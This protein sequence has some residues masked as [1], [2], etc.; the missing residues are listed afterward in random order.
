MATIVPSILE[1]SSY[2]FELKLEEILKIAKLERIQIDF[3]DGKFT[4]HKIMLVSEINVLNPAYTWEAHLMV[5]NPESYLLDCKI[6][7]FNNCLVHFE[8][9]EDKAGLEKIALMIREYKMVPALAVNHETAIDAIQPFIQ[10]FEY[11]QL[12]SVKPGY[13]G[14]EFIEATY[15]RVE[16]LKKNSPDCIIGVDGAIKFSNIKQIANLGVD[17]LVVGSALYA[18]GK[19]PTENFERLEIQIQQGP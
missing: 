12:M 6:A 10:Y 1:E 16:K 15:E 3:S 17:Y 11:I 18:E 5:E 14:S 9:F 13:Q 4:P 7:G 2:D 19:T 8:A